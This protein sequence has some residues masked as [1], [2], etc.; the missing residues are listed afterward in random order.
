MISAADFAN[1]LMPSYKSL[2]KTGN[3]E[4]K[5]ICFYRSLIIL[6][7]PLVT[8]ILCTIPSFDN[9]PLSNLPFTFIT[10]NK[11]CKARERHF[12]SLGR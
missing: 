7:K 12:S 9:L 8:N 4:N 5:L 6:T 1:L 3:P 11:C 10:L 2:Q